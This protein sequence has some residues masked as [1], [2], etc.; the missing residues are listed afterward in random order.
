MN[1][2]ELGATT[3][4]SGN[5]GQSQRLQDEYSKL[6]IHVIQAT[7]YIEIQWRTMRS[8]LSYLSKV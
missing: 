3:L 7:L 5:L 2:I 6:K 1:S 8:S 4:S